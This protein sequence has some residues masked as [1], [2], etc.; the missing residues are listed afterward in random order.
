M[1][2]YGQQRSNASKPHR[3]VLSF[4]AVFLLM[5]AAV[6]GSYIFSNSEQDDAFVIFHETAGGEV[7]ARVSGVHFQRCGQPPHRNCVIDGDTFYLGDQSIRLAGIDA[8]EINPPE[9]AREYE[10][11]EEASERLIQLLNDGPFEIQYAEGEN[12][13]QY[14]RQLRIPVRDGTSFGA[15][16]Q[17]EGLARRWA[18]RHL[19]WCQ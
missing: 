16:L 8:P 9:C 6:L 12:L 1:R 11:G 17:E 13:D 7:D 19:S 3:G 2:Q 14:G 15:V 5:I 18:G 4:V 10:L